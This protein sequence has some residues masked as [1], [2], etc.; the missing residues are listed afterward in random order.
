MGSL[1]IRGIDN[2]LAK[3]LKEK[4]ETANK[5]VNQFVIEILKKQVGLK[6]NRQYTV[7][8]NDL[9]H[10]F[11]IWTE[12]EFEQIQGKIDSERQIDAELWK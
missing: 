3:L 10:L 5:S 4:A 1:S 8:H 11:G 12:S 6:K 7:Q 9:D 2:T